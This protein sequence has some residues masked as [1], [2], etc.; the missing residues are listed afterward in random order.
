MQR[1]FDIDVLA[2]SCGGRLR[3]LATIVSTRTARA[4]LDHLGLPSEP[5]TPAPARAPPEDEIRFWH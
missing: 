5:A 4:I 1:V 2:C 3:L